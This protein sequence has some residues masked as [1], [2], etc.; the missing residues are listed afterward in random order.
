MKEKIWIKIAWLL[1][2]RLVYWCYIRMQT[3]ASTTKLVDKSQ[4]RLPV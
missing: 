3:F 1:P 2:R 4:V